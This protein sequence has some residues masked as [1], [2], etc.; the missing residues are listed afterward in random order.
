MTDITTVN[1]LEICAREQLQILDPNLLNCM[2]NIK[3]VIYVVCNLV[4]KK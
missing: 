3:C 1:E 2:C 4:S